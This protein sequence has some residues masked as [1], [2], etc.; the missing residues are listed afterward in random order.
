MK[1]KSLF[2]SRTSAVILSVAL[3]ACSGGGGGKGGDNE[4]NTDPTPQDED[5]Q[6]PQGLGGNGDA[7]CRSSDLLPLFNGLNACCINLG[8]ILDKTFPGV[9]AKDPKN[10][11]I[12]GQTCPV[13]ILSGYV[14]K[15]LGN[16]TIKNVKY[17]VPSDL[18]QAIAESTLAD[19]TGLVTIEGKSEQEPTVITRGGAFVPELARTELRSTGDLVLRNVNIEIESAGLRYQVLRGSQ[20]LELENVRIANSSVGMFIEMGR[21]YDKGRKTADSDYAEESD[22]NRK[23]ALEADQNFKPIFK[24]VEIVDVEKP[25]VTNYPISTAGIRFTKKN[26]VFAPSIT[27][28]GP[29]YGAAGR[30]DATYPYVVNDGFKLEK[31]SKL[32]IEPG[33]VVKSKAASFAVES[34]TLIAKGQLD[35]PIYF[36]SFQDDIGGDTNGD[37][38]ATSP[39]HNDWEGLY[40]G[41]RSIVDMGFV[42]FS[43]AGVSVS[44]SDLRISDKVTLNQAPMCLNLYANQPSLNGRCSPSNDTLAPNYTSLYVYRGSEVR[45]SAPLEINWDPGIVDIKKAVAVDADLNAPKE[46]PAPRGKTLFSIE[47]RGSLVFNNTTSA[48]GKFGVAYSYAC[49]YSYSIGGDATGKQLI[50]S[51]AYLIEGIK[52]DWFSFFGSADGADCKKVTL[53][54]SWSSN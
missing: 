13:T 23:L 50:N 8:D 25:L 54:T 44:N 19:V 47:E 21:F 17:L 41:G 37:G 18:D 5:P 28:T 32:T 42:T 6:G 24:N 11:V 16:L 51:D 9:D 31:G 36:T 34:A 46:T 48:N 15:K 49:S 7:S 30:L 43:Y 20:R 27:L 14:S 29:Y 40:I 12:D 52:D 45:L 4:G 2:V 35:K 1:I 38:N 39:R 33:A 53:T 10:I 22:F 26:Q 3:S